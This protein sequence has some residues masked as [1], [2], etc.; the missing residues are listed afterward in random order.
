MSVG[1]KENTEKLYTKL[2]FMDYRDDSV[3]KSTAFSS[4]SPGFNS[5]NQFGRWQSSVTQVL[6]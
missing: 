4:E 1:W 3:I 6:G 5:Q 2:N